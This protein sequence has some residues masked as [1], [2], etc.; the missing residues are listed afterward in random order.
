MLWQVPLARL[1]RALSARQRPA[2]ETN[3]AGE[4]AAEKRAEAA[5]EALGNVGGV[6]ALRKSLYAWSAGKLFFSSLLEESCTK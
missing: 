2:S 5:S 3:P 6:I 1:P 4:Q